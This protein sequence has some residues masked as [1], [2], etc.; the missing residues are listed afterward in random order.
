MPRY[1]WC[2]V[3]LGTADKEK[4]MDYVALHAETKDNLTKVFQIKKIVNPGCA[5]YSTLRKW[6]EGKSIT[7]PKEPKITSTDRILRQVKSPGPATYKNDPRPDKAF[8]IK[9]KEPSMELYN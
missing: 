7:I 9:T 8:K 3:K 1:S 2:K 6:T 5:K 4:K